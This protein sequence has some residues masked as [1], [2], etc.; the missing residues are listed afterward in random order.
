M[1]S[2]EEDLVAD[3]EADVRCPYCRETVE[4]A[5]D[6]DGGEAQEYVEDCEICCKPWQVNVHYDVEGRAEVSVS[7]LDE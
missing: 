1:D 4:I 6:P 7:P 5:I 2:P 3:S